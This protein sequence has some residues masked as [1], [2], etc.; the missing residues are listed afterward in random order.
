M[1]REIR[2]EHENTVRRWNVLG[3]EERPTCVEKFTKSTRIL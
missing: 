2:D 1:R 3:D